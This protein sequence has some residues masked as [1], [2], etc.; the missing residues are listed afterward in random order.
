M[1]SVFSDEDR[2]VYRSNGHATELDALRAAN[3]RRAELVVGG[4]LP[5]PPC[6]GRVLRVD[7]EIGA[8]ADEST[9][10]VGPV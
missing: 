8:D 6:T 1:A 5:E 4:S 9:P 10:T 3:L 7:G 2:E